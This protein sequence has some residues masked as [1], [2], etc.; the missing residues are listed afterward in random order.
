[1]SLN[2]SLDLY[3]LYLTEVTTS[4][5]QRKVSS[6]E[7]RKQWKNH[8]QAASKSVREYAIKNNVSIERAFYDVMKNSTLPASIRMELRKKLKIGSDNS[9]ITIKQEEYV[10]EIHKQAHEPHE[11]PGNQNLGKLVKRAV[12]RIDYDVDGDVDPEDKVEKAKGDYGEELPTPFGKFRTGVSKSSNKKQKANEEFS[13]WREDLIEVMQ[14]NDEINQKIK[15]KKVKNKITLYPQ[16]SEVIQELGAE[17]VEMKEVDEEEIQS[18]LNELKMPKDLG[19][20]VGEKI[21]SSVRRHN[22]A[23]EDLKDKRKK[24]PPYAALTASYSPE[25]DLVDEGIKTKLAAA[26]LAASLAAGG[27]AGINAVKSATEVG[28][29]VKSGNVEKVKKGTFAHKVAQRNKLL[30]Q[31]QGE[32]LEID[33]RALTSHEERKK[34]DYVKGMKK[35]SADFRNRYGD[36][37]KEVMY[38]TATKMAKEEVENNKEKNTLLANKKKMLQKQMMLQKQQMMLQKQGKLPMGHAMEE[39]SMEETKK[40]ALDFVR[41]QMTKKHGKSAIVGTPEYKEKRDKRNKENPRKVYMP[42]SGDEW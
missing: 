25:E 27:A 3:N 12:K 21:M 34:E 39:V 28:K 30:K 38:A 29:D 16:I 32:E 9:D 26:G 6:I 33:E 1:M 7:G 13:N 10:N 42:K 22:Q 4:I 2:N 19:K 36:R 41:Q 23:I 18:Y 17:L 15:E 11:V 31:L 37:A 14:K 5:P 8:L 20:G 40:N 35:K 24:K